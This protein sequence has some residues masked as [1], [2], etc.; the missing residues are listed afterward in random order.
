[1]HINTTESS[2]TAR[3]HKNMYRKFRKKFG[4]VSFE[5]CERTDRQTLI[6]ILRSATRGEAITS[7]MFHENDERN[8]GRQ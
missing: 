1:M 5:T 4:H 3:S 8:D 7:Q 2:R 6:A